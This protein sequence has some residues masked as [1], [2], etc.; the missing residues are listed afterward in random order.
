MVA[1]L[2][3]LRT[4]IGALGIVLGA[5]A[6][7]AAS[8]VAAQEAAKPVTISISGSETTISEALTD[9]EMEILV[10]RIALY[11]DELVAAIVAASLY[12]LQIVQAQRYLD[13]V[14]GKPGL[15]P[16]RKWDGSVVSLL[17]Y[18]EIVKM[19]SDDLDWTEALGEAVTN[20][21]KQ[22]LEA[23]QQLRDK[24]V[25]KGI[26]KS[27]DKTT[28]V[29]REDRVIVQPAKAEEIYVPVYE[30]QML[31]DPGYAPAPVSYYPEPYPSYYY[32]TA[33]YF[34]GFVA[35]AVWGA[36]IDWN[37][38]G[39]WGG[40]GGWGNDLDI[41]CNNCF[42]NRNFN[43]KVKWNDVDWNNVDRSKVNFDKSQVNKIDNDSIKNDLKNSDRN[44]VKNKA[45]DARQNRQASG[46]SGN[47][48]AKDVRK[49]T[50]EGLKKQGGNAGDR[51]G[52]Q[53]ARAGGDGA[54]QQAQQARGGGNQAASRPSTAKKSGKAKPAARA[55]NRSAKP[56]PMGDVSRGRNAK[57][58][59]SRG[60]QSMG[61]GYQRSG[62]GGGAS[63]Y[64]HGGGRGYG[65]GG[66]R[67]GGG[68]GGGRR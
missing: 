13:Q 18:P 61:G 19:M 35:G 67:G 15:E 54:R 66:G 58:H 28:V 63:V 22:L 24:A 16:D 30:P 32:P 12:P 29:H 53:Q 26:L 42:N 2:D 34:P 9:A 21:E 33:P 25:A 23:I 36:A 40:Y 17:N 49:S 6:A 60:A 44:N 46:G 7:V 27:D 62:G 43:G 20:Q 56:S 52:A 39:V 8:G 3:P 45:N 37:N 4:A 68:R 31:Y 64:R 11:P 57:S 51:G 48:K 65:G 47:R 41:D 1:P 55:D 59:S 50:M 14:K 10:A 38:W 5:A